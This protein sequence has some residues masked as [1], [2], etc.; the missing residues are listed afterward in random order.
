MTLMFAMK[1]S[2]PVNRE[3]HLKT[4]YRL[5]GVFLRFPCDLNRVFVLSPL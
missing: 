2:S 4:L 3:N 5:G 1:T